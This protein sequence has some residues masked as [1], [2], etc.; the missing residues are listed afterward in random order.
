MQKSHTLS[1]QQGFLRN[2]ATCTNLNADALG[3]YPGEALNNEWITSI[4]QVWQCNRHVFKIDADKYKR[5]L[6]AEGTQKN[7]KYYFAPFAVRY[8]CKVIVDMLRICTYSLNS[9]V[10]LW[11]K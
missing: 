3:A 6:A 2:D 8:G 11:L 7:Y 10:R 5:V 1:G 9:I 4:N